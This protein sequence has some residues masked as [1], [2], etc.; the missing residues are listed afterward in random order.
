MRAHHLHRG[1]VG[2]SPVLSAA[3]HV[4]ADAENGG[5]GKLL[6][7]QQIA[8]RCAKRYLHLVSCLQRAGLHHDVEQIEM[9]SIGDSK[10]ELHVSIRAR[11]VGKRA[12]ARA[13]LVAAAECLHTPAIAV[14]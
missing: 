14:A 7:L 13:D 1:E 11:H 5:L 9:A 2:D 8:V 10:R 4:N 6:G 3:V 12:I